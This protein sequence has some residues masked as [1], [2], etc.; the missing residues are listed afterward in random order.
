MTGRF[1]GEDYNLG[2]VDVT[3]VPY[4]GLVGGARRV[5]G[6]M[7]ALRFGAQHSQR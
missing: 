6:E 4:A 3:D 2:L 1:D 7:Y 5:H